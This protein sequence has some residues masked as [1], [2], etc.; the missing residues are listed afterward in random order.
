ME[1]HPYIVPSAPAIKYPGYS[2]TLSIV[3]TSPTWHD[4]T[5]PQQHQSPGAPCHHAGSA[6][7][8]R[9]AS[10]HHLLASLNSLHNVRNK[11]PDT[12]FP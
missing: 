2:N 8:Y 11:T 12:P 1:K 3:H 10:A 6:C 5:F 4:Q 9:M 7:L